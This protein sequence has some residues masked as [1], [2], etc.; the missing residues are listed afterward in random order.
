M[1]NSLS[2]LFENEALN[3]QPVAE[4]DI[5][6]EDPSPPTA[7]NAESMSIYVSNVNEYSTNMREMMTETMEYGFIGWSC[8]ITTFRPSA[9]E[10]LNM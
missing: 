4:A 10:H 6:Y 9:I 5:E 8:F 1:E 7:I 3:L 2:T